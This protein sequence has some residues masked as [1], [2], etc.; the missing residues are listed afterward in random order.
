MSR[1]ISR[2]GLAPT[3]AAAALLVVACG[4]LAPPAARAG[5]VAS[6]WVLPLDGP[7]VQVVRGFDPP[8]QAWL[9]GH[10]GVDLAAQDGASVQAA[11]RGVVTYAGLVAG[12]GVV[13]VS[14]G[15][16]R[17]TYEPVAA[18]VAVGQP[19]EPGEPIGALTPVA[20]HCAPAACLHWGLRR[21][22]TY[23]DPMQL[24]G[25]GP[26]RLLPL[27]TEALTSP[28]AAPPDQARRAD[29]PAPL[30]LSRAEP[31]EPIAARLARAAAAGVG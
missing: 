21:G 27:G 11:G 15:E 22:E 6:D 28:T 23:L 18:T 3:S 2:L 12:R 9:A 5:P 4:L 7:G 20:S 16:L 26:V 8:A 31:P 14:H 24:I 25:S 30:A 17:T 29:P 19:V 10:R 13:T 1:L